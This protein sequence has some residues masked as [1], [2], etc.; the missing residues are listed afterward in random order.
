MTFQIQQEDG[1]AF[2]TVIKNAWFG[3]ITVEL[4]ALTGDRA[5]EGSAG[6]KGSFAITNF[7]RSEPLEEAITYD[8][9]AKLNSWGKWIEDGAEA[10]S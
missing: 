9:T 1:D 6:P 7:S 4:C 8:V 2:L 5:V 10:G 3:S